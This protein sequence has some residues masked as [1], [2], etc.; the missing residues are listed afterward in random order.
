MNA[1][2]SHTFNSILVVVITAALHCCAAET[3]PARSSEGKGGKAG[4]FEDETL[5]VGALERKYRLLVPDSMDLSKPAPIVFAFH[6]GLIDNKELMAF[7]TQLDHLAKKE[8]FILVFPN[9]SNKIGWF[10][11]KEVARIDLSFF[12]A[13]LLHLSKQYN[14]DM[15]RVYC[16]GESSGG[17]FCHVLAQERSKVIA[18]IAPHS[19]VLASL[20]GKVE[21]ERKIPAFIIHGAADPIIKVEFGQKARDAYKAAGHE[22]EYWEIPGHGH[23]WALFRGVNEKIWD[24]FKAHPLKSDAPKT[25]LARK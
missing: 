19:A 22:I 16:T 7:Y 9:A 12:D 5:K 18:A 20:N 10:V 14:L 24:F 25:D 23:E 6:G 3:V 1:G 4:L 11:V 17:C 15:N 21:A 2:L 13:L 8:K